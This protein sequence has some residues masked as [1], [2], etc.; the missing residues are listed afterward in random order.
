L[1]ILRGHINDVSCLAVLS[2]EKIVSDSKFKIKVWDVESGT[3]LQTFGHTDIISAVI[4]ISNGKI[5]SCDEDGK[6]III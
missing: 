4:Q 1:K 6:I 3:C 5:A 2:D